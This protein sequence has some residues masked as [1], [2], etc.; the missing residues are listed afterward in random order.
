MRIA[1]PLLLLPYAPFPGNRE[2]AMAARAPRENSAVERSRRD[3]SEPHLPVEVVRVGQ[4][5]TRSTTIS[6]DWAPAARLI[7]ASA[8]DIYDQ[9]GNAVQIVNPP[10]AI[11]AYL[12]HSPTGLTSS[13]KIGS[14]INE[15]V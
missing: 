8:G 6:A 5:L 4:L 15:F 10:P 13:G 7:D 11:A 9:S 1:D 3:A 14:L 12:S 2:Q